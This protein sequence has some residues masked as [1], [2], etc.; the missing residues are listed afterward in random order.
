[1]SDKTH[2]AKDP[3]TSSRLAGENSHVN[4]QHMVLDMP[5]QADTV[6]RIARKAPNQTFLE[7]NDI[8]RFCK[9]VWQ[10]AAVSW[11]GSHPLRRSV[12]RTVLGLTPPSQSASILQ[13]RFYHCPK[14][15]TEESSSAPRQ[16]AARRPG[17]PATR[18][19]GGAA[20]RQPGSLPTRS[21]H[22]T[23]E[24]KKAH[25][26]NSLPTFRQPYSNNRTRHATCKLPANFKTTM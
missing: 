9:P 14:T 2:S 26:W 4:Y 3:T 15:Q 20:A 24:T 6:K 10:L 13:K 21:P 18:R 5:S 8:L 17:S 7:L 22:Q 12:S 25:R 19:P 23:F 11:T 1:M 16:P